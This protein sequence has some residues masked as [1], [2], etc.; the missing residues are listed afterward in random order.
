MHVVAATQVTTSTDHELDKLLPALRTPGAATVLA[1][2]V[3][4]R[5]WSLTSCAK[6][7]PPA[8]SLAI[9]PAIVQSPTAKHVRSVA[10]SDDANAPPTGTCI[11]NTFGVVHA[12]PVQVAVNVSCIPAPVVTFPN[13][14][15]VLPTQLT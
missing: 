5:Q 15:H 7:S 8:L 14:T 9:C 3:E 4:V 2:T 13:T 6:N 10:C 11:D 12:L 1:T